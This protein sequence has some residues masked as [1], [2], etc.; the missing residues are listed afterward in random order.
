MKIG[1]IE[2]NI[3]ISGPGPNKYPYA[4]MKVGDSFFVKAEDGE[5][6][7]RLCKTVR[8]ATSYWIYKKGM[9]I[10]TRMCEEEGGIRVWRVG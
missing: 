3:K 1:K 7:K 8:G 5:D 6:L 4:K 2:K 10:Q 9:D